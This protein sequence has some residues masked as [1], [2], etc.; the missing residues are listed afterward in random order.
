M[1]IAR[2]KVL[3]SSSKSI[4]T[5]A[6]LAYASPK[7]SQNVTINVGHD[8]TVV[9]NGQDQPIST[10]PIHIQYPPVDTTSTYNPY[11]NL[12]LPNSI[13]EYKMIL[14]Q[15][16]KQM[17]ALGLIIEI[18]KSN[19]L[20]VNKYI[21]AKHQY[22]NELIRLLTNS[23]SVEFIEKD[24]DPGCLCDCSNLLYIDKIFVRKNNEIYN[25]KYHF[26]YVIKILEEH[27]ISYKITT[28]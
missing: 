21:I 23:T 5:K 22:L 13:D 27:R 28:Y 7:Q 17:E 2:S 16:D 10:N 9:E 12:E 1:T 19:P 15:K 18:I 14:E 20:I 6:S 24:I 25:L 11:Q 4:I 3:S 8:K 26:D